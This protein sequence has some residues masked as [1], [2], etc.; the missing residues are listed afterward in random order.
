VS[1]LDRAP[2]HSPRFASGGLLRLAYEEKD[3]L[4]QFGQHVVEELPRPLP[5]LVPRVLSVGNSKL[6]CGAH[7]I[8]MATAVTLRNASDAIAHSTQ[9]KRNLPT[10][11]ASLNNQSK[12]RLNGLGLLCSGGPPTGSSHDALAK[13]SAFLCSTTSS[14]VASFGSSLGAR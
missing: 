5:F 10:F 6:T 7:E 14:A 1:W 2:P 8:P 12:T 13:P 4:M 11:A 3:R 9:V